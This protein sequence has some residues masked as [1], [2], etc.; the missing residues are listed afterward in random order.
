[1]NALS[2]T[3]KSYDQCKRF[4]RQTNGQTDRPKTMCPDQ[5]MWGHKKVRK[6]TQAHTYC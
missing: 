5:S 2:I 4:C 3:I 6:A 1:M